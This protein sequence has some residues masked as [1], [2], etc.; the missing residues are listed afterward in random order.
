MWPPQPFHSLVRVG[1]VSVV[2]ALELY[3]IMKGTLGGLQSFSS[4]PAQHGF[5]RASVQQM[6][7][8][9]PNLGLNHV[10]RLFFASLASFGDCDDDVVGIPVLPQQ[11][12][13]AQIAQDVAKFVLVKY[14]NVTVC[15]RSQVCLG[16]GQ[17][18]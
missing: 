11:T 6:Y 1:K 13:V 14:C 2:G 5:A 18:R 3:G 7:E 15:Y 10:W 16:Q 4:I 12:L 8:L 9:V 17:K